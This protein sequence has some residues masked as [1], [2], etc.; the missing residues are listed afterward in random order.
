MRTAKDK[1]KLTSASE[2]VSRSRNLSEGAAPYR[3]FFD[4]ALSVVQTDLA[5]R[6]LDCNPRL[7]T[8]LLA[9]QEDIKARKFASLVA[10][11]WRA[12]EEEAR[13]EVLKNGVTEEYEIELK[14]ADGAIISVVVKKWLQ[15]DRHGEAQ[16]I[17]MVVRDNTNE[18]QSDGDDA[19]YQH[20]ISLLEKQLRYQSVSANAPVGI[21]TIDKSARIDSTN[22]AIEELLGYEAGT[23][24]GKQ[25]LARASNLQRA[26]NR[27]PSASCL[28][29]SGHRR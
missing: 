27:R 20:A 18:K 13:A 6:I 14:K 4:S 8:M 19:V 17:W 25:N 23:L 10:D 28:L 5:G 26:S 22:P 1:V 12:K 2:P 24:I 11:P 29:S 15:I 9:G 16:G 21:L 3:S 7:A